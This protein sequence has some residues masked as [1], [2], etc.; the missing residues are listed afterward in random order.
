V[1]EGSWISHEVS[2]AKIKKISSFSNA[3]PTLTAVRIV[4][5]TVIGR[6]RGLE[7][8]E[9][10]SDRVFQRALHFPRDRALLH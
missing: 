5:G 10:G 1:I 3:L 9:H 7:L 8:A 4:A 2:V 6:A